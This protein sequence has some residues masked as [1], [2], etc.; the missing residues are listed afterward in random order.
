MCFTFHTYARWLPD[1]PRALTKS[2]VAVLIANLLNPSTDDVSE[3]SIAKVS[4]TLK[5]LEE[6]A[7]ALELTVFNILSK[8][9]HQDIKCP[10]LLSI[11][12]GLRMS[13]LCSLWTKHQK[14]LHGQTTIDRQ[15]YTTLC[16]HPDMRICL[17]FCPLL[18]K[19]VRLQLHFI[20]QLEADRLM[21]HMAA[22][23]CC[24]RTLLE[25]CNSGMFGPF[26]CQDMQQF[27]KMRNANKFKSMQQAT[28]FLVNVTP[29]L[30]CL[31][32]GDRQKVAQICGIKPK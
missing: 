32:A 29:F 17:H 20:I 2:E 30:V 12:S 26:C 22:K 6:D 25:P 27:V 24:E 8:R 28:D 1:T 10:L 5:L 19:T 18:Q 15:M 13:Q 14:E 16:V 9:H 7:F 3:E 21:N 31:S 11:E 23:K 4:D